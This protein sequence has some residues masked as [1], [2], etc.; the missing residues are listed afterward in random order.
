MDANVS[1]SKPQQG[2]KN[3]ELGIRTEIKNIG[4]IRGVAN[5]IKY[6]INRQVTFYLDRRL[7]LSCT[8]ISK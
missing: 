7:S 8:S 2:D 4:S 6:E 3:I 5:A 1:L